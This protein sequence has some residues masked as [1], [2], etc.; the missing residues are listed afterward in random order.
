[1]AGNIFQ[2][3]VATG[4][5][6]PFFLI[7]FIVFAVLD[8]SGILGKGKKQLNAMVAGVVALIFIGALFDKVNILENLILFL[9]ISLV[10]IFVVLV[11]W[12]FVSSDEKGLKL[13]PGL[14]N[15]LIAII[16]IAVVF[17]VFWALGVGQSFFDWLF[18]SS[19][20]DT[21]WTNAVFLILIA[22][23]LAA[24]KTS[25]TCSSWSGFRRGI[26]PRDWFPQSP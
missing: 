21:F 18:K 1:M 12:G 9:T 8:K 26:A 6:Y 2:S 19:W 3:E 11:L 23:A 7:F 20:S 22:A 5:I 24:R 17:G 15:G 25:G 13:S 14:V 10:I 4:F 16:G